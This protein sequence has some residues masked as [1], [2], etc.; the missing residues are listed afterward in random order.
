MQ[1]NGNQPNTV[2]AQLKLTPAVFEHI[3]ETIGMKKAE[4]G[5][6]LGGCRETGEVTHFFFDEAASE[7]SGVAYTPNNT[8]LNNVLKTEWRPQG[9]DYV[10]SIHSHPPYYRRPSLGDEVYA[11][12]ILEAL[13]LPYLL[14]P[15]VTTVPDT[16]SFTLFPFAAVNNGGNVHFVEQDLVV[17]EPVIICDIGKKSNGSNELVDSTTWELLAIL[18]CA[19]LLTFGIAMA[20]LVRW[21]KQHRN[22]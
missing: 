22:V 1:H 21:Q 12:R 3:R 15:I 19:G 5:G 14:C 6:I 10:G 17:G 9:I 18:S 7:Q 11:K 8:T 2:P 20:Q 16:G 13:D 4:T